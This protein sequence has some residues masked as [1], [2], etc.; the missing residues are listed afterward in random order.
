MEPSWSM[1]T[2]RRRA[3]SGEQRFEAREETVKLYIFRH[4]EAVEGGEHLPDGWRYLTEKGRAATRS[5]ASHLA[6]HGLSSCRILSSPLVRAVQTAQIVAEIC[7]P[8]CRIEISGLLAGG[9]IRSVVD[10]LAGLSAKNVM[11]VGHEPQL[12]M[13]VATL[14]QHGEALPIRKS[15]CV[16]LEFQ[17]ARPQQ[18]STFVAC[19]EPGKGRISSLKKFLSRV[20]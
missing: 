2:S 6:S 20:P 10:L 9:D 3:A 5:I 13:L 4:G 19:L 17:P 7:G 1:A 16:L 18:A 8:S 14:L 15:G 12:G 11:L